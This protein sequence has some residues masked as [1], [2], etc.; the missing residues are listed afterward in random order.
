MKK[1]CVSLTSSKPT[2][3]CMITITDLGNQANFHNLSI[4]HKW[5]VS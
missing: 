1:T 3:F 2:E 5:G 4:R